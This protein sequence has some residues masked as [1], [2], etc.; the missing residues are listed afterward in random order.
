MT[1]SVSVR[2][3]VYDMRDYVADWSASAATFNTY[4]Q[5]AF[6]AAAGGELAVPEGAYKLDISAD[7]KVYTS[8]N[9]TIKG[10]GGVITATG[11]NHD[12]TDGCGFYVRD[13]DGAKVNIVFDGLRFTGDNDPFVWNAEANDQSMCIRVYLDTTTGSRD[14]WVKNC[15]FEKL[16]GFSAQF[17]VG[18]ASVAYQPRGMGGG[19][20]NN[21]MYQCKNG[22]NIS[23]PYGKVTGNLFIDSE[24]IESA[25]AFM[26][27]SENVFYRPY[28]ALSIGGDNT[29][30]RPT[31]GLT[32][33][34]NL[35]FLNRPDV[36]AAIIMA[37]NSTGSIVDGNVI[38]RSGGYAIHA[39]VDTD[40]EETYIINNVAINCGYIFPSRANTTAYVV[41]DLVEPA[42]PNGYFYLCTVAGTSGGSIPTWPTGTNSTV[43]DGT[44]TW[45][46]RSATP[47]RVGYFVERPYVHFTNNT[48]R[49][50][51]L[52]TNYST[53]YGCLWR[54]SDGWID[55]N[56]FVGTT[57]DIQFSTT[58]GGFLRNYFG[59]GNQYDPAKVNFS[60][61]P[62]TDS[63]FRIGSVMRF[64]PS[65]T[66]SRPTAGIEY[67]HLRAIT[68]GGVGVADTDA[69]CTKDSAN[70][71]GW[72][73]LY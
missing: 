42:T 73:A 31:Y 63:G 47:L 66:G 40:A 4:W 67:R 51:S 69:V 38:Y 8:S 59:A 5:T 20:V 13:T 24:G 29:A 72:R 49:N 41:G 52:D 62:T 58:N 10:Y 34:N 60:S 14:I 39:P 30:G 22:A 2:P 9:T 55:H 43:T 61:V 36:T 19:F 35:I 7:Q 11:G 23:I 1:V 6:D 17:V 71:Y 46:R 54:G 33:R 56:K 44:V 45:Q 26:D 68:E 12:D 65:G 48:V 25:A 32:A 27:L 3:T 37:E 28:G 15:Y 18:T 53:Q 16:W 21:T 50:D 70:A 57:W 64:A